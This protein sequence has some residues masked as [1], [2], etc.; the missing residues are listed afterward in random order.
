L[1]HFHIAGQRAHSHHTHYHNHATY[2][3]LNHKKQFTIWC[4]NSI[5]VA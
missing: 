3:V 1:K 2:F 4:H 5:L